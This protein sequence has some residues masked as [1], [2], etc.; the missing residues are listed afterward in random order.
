MTTTQTDKSM[1]ALAEILRQSGIE[2]V[3]YSETCI[4]FYG[5]RETAFSDVLPIVRTCLRSLK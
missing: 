1:A 2:N 5:N 4:R 3:Q